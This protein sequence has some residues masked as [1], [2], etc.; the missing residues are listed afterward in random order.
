M[1][2]EGFLDRWRNWM[3]DAGAQA[4]ADKITAAIGASLGRLAVDRL[5]AVVLEIDTKRTCRPELVADIPAAQAFYRLGARL[6]LGSGYVDHVYA[7]CHR[8]A[9]VAAALACPDIAGLAAQYHLADPWAADHLATITCT[10][11]AFVGMSPLNRGTL[12]DRAAGIPRDRLVAL[13]WALADPRV[14]AV[15][16]TMSS[17][18]HLED[19]IRTLGCPE[20]IK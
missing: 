1:R 18:E 4:V 19:V 6:A 15:A 14:S 11:R 20:P 5:H 3:L 10:G 8:P 9:H 12:V 16:I 13:Q 17:V 2:I 7:Y